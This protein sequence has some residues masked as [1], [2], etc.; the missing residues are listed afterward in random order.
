MQLINVLDDFA[1]VI[2]AGNLVFDLAEDFADFVFDG[3]RPAGLLLETV[4]IR[5]EFLI[6]E[7]D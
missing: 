7:I 6:D 1:Q 3:I 2:A 5:K 4:Q